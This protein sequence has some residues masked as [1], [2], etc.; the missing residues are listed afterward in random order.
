MYNQLNMREETLVFFLEIMEN[1][2]LYHKRNNAN[3]MSIT[4]VNVNYCQIKV[5]SEVYIYEDV[6]S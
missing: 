6:R 2:P 5:V 1:S 4:C 3:E